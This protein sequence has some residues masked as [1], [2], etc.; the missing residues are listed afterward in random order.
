MSKREGERKRKKQSA[1]ERVYVRETES[2]KVCVRE[3]ESEK[4]GRHS[5]SE[6]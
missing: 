3:T 5:P 1:R 6:G 2:E 4:V